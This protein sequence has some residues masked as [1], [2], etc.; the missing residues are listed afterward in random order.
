MRVLFLF[1][2]LVSVK[3]F[4]QEAE[5]GDLTHLHALKAG[6]PIVKVAPKYPRQGT[7]RPTPGCAV[8]TFELIPKK[9]TDGKA[10]IPSSL[11]VYAASEPR[12]GKVSIQA[13]EKWLYLAK[14]VEHAPLY[15]TVM[16]FELE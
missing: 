2:L 8:I 6:N 11:K 16:Q 5:C 3:S 12:F 14:N 13:I 1:L 9:G 15:Y 4:A 7:A 10:L